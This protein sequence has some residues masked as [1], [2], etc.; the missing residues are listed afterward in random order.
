M[1]AVMIQSNKY[2][3]KRSTDML[4]NKNGD[5]LKS[6]CTVV[7]HQA[8]CQKTM[9]AGIAKVIANKYPG[10]KEADK[11]SPLSPEE[12]LGTFTHYEDDDVTVVNLY[13]QLRYGRKGNFTEYDKLESAI[14]QFFTYGLNNNLDLSKV[15]V[16]YKIGSGLAGGDWDVVKSL[17]SRQSEKHKVDIY[18][19]KLQ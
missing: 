15:G 18:I 13:G 17:L 16:P 7:M 10:A 9:G 4:I 12:R 19:Y 5:L 14:D 8:N 11:L 6:D 2:G 3:L 1:K